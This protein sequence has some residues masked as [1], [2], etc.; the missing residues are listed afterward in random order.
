MCKTRQNFS[1]NRNVLSPLLNLSLPF[2]RVASKLGIIK[3]HKAVINKQLTQAVFFCKISKLLSR[4]NTPLL[5]MEWD[6]MHKD[7]S[8]RIIKLFGSFNW[9]DHTK[10]LFEGK[11]LVI[12]SKGQCDRGMLFWCISTRLQTPKFLWSLNHFA[13]LFSDLIYSFINLLQNSFEYDCTDLM[14]FLELIPSSLKSPGAKLL[15]FFMM[16][17]LGVNASKSL[18]VVTAL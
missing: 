1:Q 12:R 10:L 3:K 18:G 9:T 2:S 16:K 15:T 4:Q 17:S 11:A 5:H 7:A 6:S 13:C 8:G 14:F